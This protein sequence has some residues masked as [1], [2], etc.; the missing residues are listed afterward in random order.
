[1]LSDPLLVGIA[2]GVVFFVGF[3]AAKKT[4]PLTVP[5]YAANLRLVGGFT[6]A[7]FVGW[8]AGILT[9]MLAYA[10]LSPVLQYSFSADQL[11]LP[12]IGKSLL[13]AGMGAGQAAWSLRKQATQAPARDSQV[14]KKGSKPASTNNNSY[15]EALAEIEEGRVDKGTWARSF[16]DSDGDESKAKAAYINSR[17]ISIE[18]AAELTNTRP[19][20]DAPSGE[21]ASTVSATSTPKAGNF[22]VTTGWLFGGIAVAGIVAA[23]ALPAYQDYSKR[24]AVAATQ[25]QAPAPQV[26]VSESMAVPNAQTGMDWDKVVIRPPS[27]L[28]AQSSPQ[29]SRSNPPLMAVQE[30][31]TEPAFSPQVQADLDAI[32]ARAVSDFPYLDTPAGQEVLN[33]IVQKRDEYIR[34]GQYPSVALTNAVNAFAPANAPRPNQEKRLLPVF[35]PGDKGNHTGFDPKCRWVT[36][37]DWSCK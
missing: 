27:A 3:F 16:A 11:F 12:L 6:L 25:V 34:Q 21:P 9:A 18:S 4:L 1:M 13:F 2:Q 17:A 20:D 24:R 33:K 15:A 19:Q 36:P 5:V 29:V 10:L 7:L 30:S 23:V 31:A 14:R 22:N 32:A 26:D 35:E 8:M 28:P 37:Q